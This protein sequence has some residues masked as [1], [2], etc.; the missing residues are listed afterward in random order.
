M[1]EQ[2]LSKLIPAGVLLLLGIIE[3]IGALTQNQVLLYV[4]FIPTNTVIK[5]SRE[6]P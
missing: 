3:A 6:L 5:N 2:T 4:K 1:E